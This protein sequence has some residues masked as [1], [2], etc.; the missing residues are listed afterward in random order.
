MNHN[1]QTI[2][3]IVSAHLTECKKHVDI[4]L[5]GKAINAIKDA[6][7][8]DP[9]NIYVIALEKQ[10]K[11][12]SDLSKKRTSAEA[13]KKEVR[14]TIPEIIRRA[15]ED[16][17]KRAEL[18]AKDPGTG[19]ADDSEIADPYTRE[20]DLALKKLRNQFV[21]RAEEC[22]DRGDYQNALEE[23]RRIFIIDP[24]NTIA[25]D[26]EKKIEQLVTFNKNEEV[27]HET[28]RKRK[29]KLP[30]GKMIP[31][32]IALLVVANIV[33][34]FFSSRGN[35]DD[36]FRSGRLPENPTAYVVPEEREVDKDEEPR[37]E[38]DPAVRSQA[39]ILSLSDPVSVRMSQPV[40]AD[41]EPLT[42][43]ENRIT[44]RIEDEVAEDLSPEVV[45]DTVVRYEEEVSGADDV[46]GTP[47]EGGV[48]RIATVVVSE[49]SN[50]QILEQPIY[51]SEA[52]ERGIE[53]DVVVRVL[54][55]SAGRAAETQ[56]ETSDHPL[57]LESALAS[58]RHSRFMPPNASDVFSA[59]WVSVP[60]KFRIHP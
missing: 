52:L 60:Y 53:G 32:V 55:D 25:R 28:K 39:S 36:M 17:R 48:D 42:I 56:I 35:D 46:G 30:F 14:D 47:G 5:Y 54:V 33:V 40:E 23:I 12:L 24:H 37:L 15:I 27:K 38:R 29:R 49:R 58:I 26:L 6:K 1:E 57:L 19:P 4:E 43:G 21:K 10:V 45:T 13:Y 34:I 7:F 8:A 41:E 22:I 20:R 51:P 44:I 31:A 18:K 59:G 2:P 11:L 9:R 3:E 50:I 16:S